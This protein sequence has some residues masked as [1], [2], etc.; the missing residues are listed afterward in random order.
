L[1]QPTLAKTELGRIGG[2]EQPFADV[3]FMNF[4]QIAQDLYVAQQ[5]NDETLVW[6][7]ETFPARIAEFDEVRDQVLQ[8]WK[9]NKARELAMADAKSMAGKV[10]AGQAL[11]EIF[12]SATETGAFT[13]FTMDFM[14]G[15][16]NLTPVRGT[17]RIGEE[18]MEVATSLPVSQ[19]GTAFNSD[20]SMVYLVQKTADGGV[21]DAELVSQ[22]FRSVDSFRDYPFQVGVLSR[23]REF[24][25]GTKFIENL[26]DEYNVNFLD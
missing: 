8:F 2:P 20:R 13:W 12:P 19:V 18:F 11:K 15:G 9:M 16:V 17:E 23:Q 22:F 7:T 21:P 26:R 5:I 24:L 14:R 10:A 4:E 3:L 25:A 6:V 1:D